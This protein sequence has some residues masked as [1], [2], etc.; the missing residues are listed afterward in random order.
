MR[1]GSLGVILEAGSHRPSLGRDL[2]CISHG[3]RRGTGHQWKI[4]VDSD[5]IQVKSVS[6]RDD[7]RAKQNKTP[8]TSECTVFSNVERN[9]RDHYFK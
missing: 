9:S 3:F 2:E 6:D 1:Q 7:P 5:S 8:A 4:S